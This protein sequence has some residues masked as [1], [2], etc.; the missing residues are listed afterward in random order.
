[1]CNDIRYVNDREVSMLNGGIGAELSYTVAT[2]QTYKSSLTV[3]RWQCD[4]IEGNGGGP[5]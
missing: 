5:L 4:C 1:M 3:R 2:T